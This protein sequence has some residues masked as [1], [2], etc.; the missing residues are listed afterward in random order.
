MNALAAGPAG[1]S[2]RQASAMRP[3]SAGRVSV[4]ACS[5][6]AWALVTD[7]GS[8][9]TP[10]PRLTNSATSCGSP[11]SKDAGPE[12]HAQ[13]GVVE[14]GTQAGAAGQ[15]D[16]H[17]VP[18]EVQAARRPAGQRV[19]RRICALTPGTSTSPRG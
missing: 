17:P 12:A 7:A 3:R 5:C 15:A 18:D 10:R 19:G 11:A 13:A 9:A 8:G 2:A 14:V 6:P 16:Q 1:A 4:M